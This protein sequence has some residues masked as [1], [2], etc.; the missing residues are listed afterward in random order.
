MSKID[1]SNFGERGGEKRNGRERSPR[2]CEKPFIGMEFLPVRRSLIIKLSDSPR[3]ENSTAADDIKE[4]RCILHAS[5]CSPRAAIND[6]IDDINRRVNAKHERSTFPCATLI[7]HGG[8]S[9][10]A[11]FYSVIIAL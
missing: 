3:G 8:S 7:K 4:T 5:A 11:Q 1:R 9:L 2:E 10:R 6:C